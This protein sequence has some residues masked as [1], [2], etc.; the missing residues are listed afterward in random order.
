MEADYIFGDDMPV[1]RESIRTRC[2]FC[3][4]ATAVVSHND[5]RTD[6]TRVDLYCENSRCAVREMAVIALRVGEWNPRAGVIF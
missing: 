1:A 4:G 6:N 2:P 3:G 5:V